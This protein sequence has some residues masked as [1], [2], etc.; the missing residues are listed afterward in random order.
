MFCEKEVFVELLFYFVNADT[1]FPS[2]ASHRRI[3]PLDSPQ[4]FAGST[5]TKPP[6]I[7][8]LFRITEVDATFVMSVVLDDV[9]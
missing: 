3:A 1:F 7:E 8:A 6:S 4:P 5:Y 2:M 9:F